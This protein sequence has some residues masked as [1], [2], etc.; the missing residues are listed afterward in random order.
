MT[1]VVIG[2][3]L[4]AWFAATALVQL[5]I[6][7]SKRLVRLDTAGVLPSW[8]FFAPVPG[9]SDLFLMCRDER[10]D[11]SITGWQD[12]T[13]W[14]D[15]RSFNLVWNPGRRDRKA[16]L[17]IALVLADARAQDVRASVIRASVPYLA[18]LNYVSALPRPDNHVRTQF[19]IAHRHHGFGDEVPGP[20][21]V[22]ERHALGHSAA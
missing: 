20:T 14:E 8:R 3:A 1:E 18:I 19:V 5:E 22:S 9:R 15:R 11:G 10:D 16:L 12:V 6:K 21:F 13:P 17:D 2:A 7:V 4:A